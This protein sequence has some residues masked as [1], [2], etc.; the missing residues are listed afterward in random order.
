MIKPIIVFCGLPGSGKTHLSTGLIARLI[1]YERFNTDDVRRI[2]G[3]KNFDRGDTETVNSYM[4]SRA[5]QILKNSGGVAFD[6]AYWSKEARDRVYKIGLETDNKVLLI[7]CFC[8]EKEAVRR[9]PLRD[10]GNGLL[11]TPTNDPGVYKEYAKKWESPERD[12]DESNPHVSLVRFDTERGLFH[13]VK[14]DDKLE[15]FLKTLEEL[16]KQ[17]FREK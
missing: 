3:F 13:K 17:A 6:S 7:E 8:S 14:V 12:L 9:I 16:L 2:L 11:H 10:A 1:E 15:D 4:Y 5:K